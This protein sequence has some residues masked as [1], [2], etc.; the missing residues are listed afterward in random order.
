MRRD[1]MGWDGMECW[2]W[3][4]GGGSMSGVFRCR[5]RAGICGYERRGRGRGRGGV[6][7]RIRCRADDRKHD[8]Y[9]QC[10]SLARLRERLPLRLLLP[11]RPTSTCCCHFDLLLPPPLLPPPPAAAT[12]ACRLPAH[13]L[14]A[15]LPCPPASSG[16]KRATP[17]PWLRTSAHCHHG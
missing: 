9:G 2:G 15:C 17:T 12:S 10:V 14:P 13:C 7:C 4:W 3:W 8:G 1:G 16:G 6:E 11:L 5:R